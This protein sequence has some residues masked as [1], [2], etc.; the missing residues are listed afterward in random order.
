MVRARRKLSCLVAGVEDAKYGR[1][2]LIQDINEERRGGWPGR[3][4]KPSN[5]T[6]LILLLRFSRDILEDKLADYTR[7]KINEYNKENL[8]GRYALSTLSGVYILYC[9]DKIGRNILLNNFIRGCLKDGVTS[10]DILENRIAEVREKKFK[11]DY[12]Y[13]I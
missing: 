5:L 11:P 8:F 7:Y 12:K 3:L 13:F 6:D 1:D 10:K 4:I 2:V 9:A